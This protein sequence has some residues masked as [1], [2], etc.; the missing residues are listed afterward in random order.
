MNIYYYKLFILQ[1]KIYNFIIIIVFNKRY[2]YKNILKFNL[3]KMF[4]AKN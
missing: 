2:L 4:K 1:L 3:L